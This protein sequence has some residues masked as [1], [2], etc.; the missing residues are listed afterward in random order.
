MSLLVSSWENYNQ[1]NQRNKTMS[2]AWI[3]PLRDWILKNIPASAH[4]DSSS[5]KNLLDYGCSHFDLGLELEKHFQSLH[6]FDINEAVIDTNIALY[7]DQKTFRF[8][9]KINQIP[10]GNY[11]VIVA[12]SVFQY[13]Q[14][15]HLAREFFKQAK[16][17][18]KPGIPAQ[19]IVTD[20]IP[21]DYSP[22][23][24]AIE[25]LMY[26]FVIGAPIAMLIHLFKAAT[27]PK[28]LQLRRY[29]LDEFTR[30]ANSEGFRVEKLEKNLTPSR[31]RYS[32]LLTMETE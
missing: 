17:F 24:D 21:P 10:Q 12:A 2:R 4:K 28:E 1:W 9:S 13:F 20:L 3:I 18:F 6:G 14:T 7:K 11:D 25:N 27:K 22:A 19:L 32:C 16:S 26:S 15:E 23:R 31:R 8:F 5:S 30:L 29:S